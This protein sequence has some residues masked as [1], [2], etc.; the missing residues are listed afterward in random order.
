MCSKKMINFLFLGLLLSACSTFKTTA[1][2]QKTPPAKLEKLVKNSDKQ[3]LRINVA[4]NRTIPKP[5]KKV[6]LVSFYVIDPGTKTVKSKNGYLYKTITFTNR[7]LTKDGAS[8][9]ATGFYNVSISAMKKAFKRKGITLVT[10][11]EFYNNKKAWDEYDSLTVN[12]SLFGN[13]FKELSA[14]FSNRLKASAVAPGYRLFIAN[15]DYKYNNAIGQLC[16]IFNVD[17]VALMGIKVTTERSDYAIFHT[18]FQLI[19]KDPR[20]KVKRYSS[21]GDFVTDFG[22]NKKNTSNVLTPI[23]HLIVPGQKPVKFAEMDKA[24]G[25][26][27]WN[28]K[29]FD[30]L[31]AAIAD[32]SAEFLNKGKVMLH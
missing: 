17:A 16:K 10:P 15:P 19:G 28:Y 13:F 23:I 24:K 9:V 30:K 29:G 18:D 7:A 6:A 3:G 21:Y 14:M 31:A 22:S 5:V 27:D 20:P 12:Y 32:K 26:W 2:F 1:D 11:D 25:G 4:G 8:E